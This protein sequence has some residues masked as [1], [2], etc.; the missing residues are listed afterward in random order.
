MLAAFVR[1]VAGDDLPALGGDGPVFELAAADQAEVESL[2]RALGLE[3]PV[4]REGDGFQVNDGDAQL[5]VYGNSW[6]YSSTAFGGSGSS[7]STGVATAEPGVRCAVQE[8]GTEICEDVAVPAEPVEP[9]EPERPADLPTEDEA[10][11]IALALLAEAGFD[12]DGADVRA[13]DL[14]TL[15]SVSVESPVEGQTAV[16]MGAYLSIGSGGA[17][18][19]GGGL[20][21]VDREGRRLPADRHRGGDRPVE[22]ERSVLRRR[23]AGAVGWSDRQRRCHGGGDTA[24]ATRRR[25]RAGDDHPARRRAGLHPDLSPAARL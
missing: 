15:W 25:R 4:E 11:D 5:S 16:G 24:V 23:P 6:T 17:V 13:D 9:V 22:R 1:Y 20:I 7:G 2:A 21:G 12:T 10:K 8:D 18:I 3:A 19:D 14:I